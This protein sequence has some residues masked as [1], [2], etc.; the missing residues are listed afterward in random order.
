MESRHHWISGLYNPNRHHRSTPVRLPS[1]ESFVSRLV[2]VL[3]TNQSQ[4]ELNAP[5]VVIRCEKKSITSNTFLSLP[6]CIP[7]NAAQFGLVSSI[8]TLGG[9]LG[10]VSSGHVLTKHGRLLTMRLTSAFFTVGPLFE[11]LA[12][13]MALL[14][15]GR[16]ISGVGAGSAVVVVPIYISETAPLKQRGVF[17]AFSQ[18]MTN[19]GILIAQTLGYFLSHDQFWR[20]ILLVGGA[21][22]AFQILGLL[23]IVESPKWIAVNGQLVLARRYLA[24][25]RGKNTDI[26]EEVEAWGLADTVTPECKISCL[27]QMTAVLIMLQRKSKDFSRP[28][29][30]RIILR[31]HP[32]NTRVLE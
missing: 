20:I 16:F 30:S 7:M 12:P 24:R 23:L 28:P 6:Q 13:G 3:L 8:F 31:Q 1:G 18:V 10:A 29:K 32:H 9:F 21:I 26:K 5:E 4:A 19:F 14:S 15:I 25:L 11:A 17:G 22:G 2:T 27:E